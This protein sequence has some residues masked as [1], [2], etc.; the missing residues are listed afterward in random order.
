MSAKNIKS[1]QKSKL[2]GIDVLDLGTQR[3]TA[4]ADGGVHAGD[5]IFVGVL[6][7]IAHVEAGLASQN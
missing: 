6:S 5:G 3:K 1:L 7:G 4:I 2:P